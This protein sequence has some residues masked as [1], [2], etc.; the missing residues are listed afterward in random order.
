MMIATEP[1]PEDMWNTIGLA[2]RPTF[3]DSRH[4]IVYGQRTADG[5][6]AF[7]GRGAPYHFGSAIRPTFDTNTTMRNRI[8]A[9]LIDL[10]PAIRERASPTTGVV[11]WVFREIGHAQFT[12]I[13][14]MAS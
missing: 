11:H 2:N 13:G 8:R 1:L 9:A 6:L 5:R 3:D 4:L 10:F 12:Q 7:G 14:T